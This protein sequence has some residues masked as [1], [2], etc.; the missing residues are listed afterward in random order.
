[1]GFR[2]WR[3]LECRRS[4]SLGTQGPPLTPFLR[5]ALAGGYPSQTVRNELLSRARGPA[6]HS[7]ETLAA[8]VRPR[9]KVASRPLAVRYLLRTGS[10]RQDSGE[11]EHVASGHPDGPAR[12]GWH[13]IDVKAGSHHGQGV[14]GLVEADHRLVDLPAV[15]QMPGGPEVLRLGVEAR[16][17]PRRPG[18]VVEERLEVRSIRPSQFGGPRRRSDG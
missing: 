3:R 4:H 11:E 7:L 14:R 5:R 2:A 8:L 16:R 6:T 12:H 10:R 13:G 18:A 17:R 1:M 9:R 15:R